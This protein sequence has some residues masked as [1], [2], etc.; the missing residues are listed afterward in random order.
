M[1]ADRARALLEA[2]RRRLLQIIDS[3]RETQF[4]EVEQ[5]RSSDVLTPETHPSDQAQELFDRE[6]ELSVLGHAEAELRE[7]EHALQKVEDG[8]YGLDEETGQPIP[9]ERLEAVPATR[10]NVDTQ[11]RDEKRA[12]IL[13][14]RTTDLTEVEGADPT[15]TRGGG[16]LAP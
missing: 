4:G 3:S 13:D 7:V 16:R 6:E 15:A 12:G 14:E 10:Y 11:R 2:E 9:D 8:T 5:E 1:D